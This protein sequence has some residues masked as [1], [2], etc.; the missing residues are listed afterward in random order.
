MRGLVWIGALGIWLV[1][2]DCKRQRPLS[3][4]MSGSWKATVEHSGRVSKDPI[5]YRYP[6]N[7][8]SS[9]APPTAK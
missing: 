6:T 5:V 7:L 8:E 2:S 9:T 1:A 4:R 3:E